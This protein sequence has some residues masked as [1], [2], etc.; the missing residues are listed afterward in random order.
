[1]LEFRLPSLGAEMEEGTILEWK[2]APGDQV[3]KG[4]VV[5]IVVAETRVRDA[6]NTMKHPI[7]VSAS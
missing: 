1:M 7:T 3:K 5:A 2:I 4:D 6:E